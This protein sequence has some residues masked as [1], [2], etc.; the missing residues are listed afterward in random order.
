M[1]V[2]CDKGEAVAHSLGLTVAQDTIPLAKAVA[3]V[4]APAVIRALSC[5][6]RRE[7]C[8][9]HGAVRNVHGERWRALMR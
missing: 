8:E 2:T 6:L 5:G 9:E 3:I 4:E 1:K 7:Q